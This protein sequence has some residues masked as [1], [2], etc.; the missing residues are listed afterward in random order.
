MTH[1]ISQCRCLKSL[2]AAA[3]LV[4]VSFAI[5][6]TASAQT[7]F[8]EQ[9]ENQG[10]VPIGGWGP[11]GLS[12]NG[13]I[14]KNYSNPLGPVAW[15][16]GCCWG[17]VIN[18]LSGTGY[19]AAYQDSSGGS[20]SQYSAW[21]ILPAISGQQA[22]DVLT[23]YTISSDTSPFESVHFE[24]RY[25]PSG[26]VNAGPGATD[27]GD[28]S[29]V[30]L[31]ISPMPNYNSGIYDG[32]TKWE[33]TLPGPGRIAFRQMGSESMYFGVEDVSVA[34][35]EP[36][37]GPMPE[38]FEDLDGVCGEGPCRLI[39]EQGW[40]FQDKGTISFGPAWQPPFAVNEFTPHSGFSFMK[41]SKGG[42]SGSVSCWAVLPEIGNVQGDTLNF[43]VRGGMQEG[44][45]FQVRYSPTGATT[46]GSGAAAVGSFT[47]V[48]AEFTTLPYD[49]WLQVGVDIPGDGRLALRVFDANASQ[50]DVATIVA[51]DTMALNQIPA[52]PPIPLAN[53]T[54]TWTPA[55]NPVVVNTNILIP[56]GATLILEPGTLV[57]IEEDSSLSV[58]GALIGH[59]TESDPVMFE[60]AAVF[61]PGLTGTGTLDLAYAHINTNI[62]PAQHGS[63]LFDHCT[64]EGPYAYIFNSS[65]LIVNDTDAPAFMSLDH[66]TFADGALVCSDV[67]LRL[68]N[69]SFINGT[70]ALPL[71]G[72]IYVDNLSFDGGSLSISRDQQDVYVNNITVTNSPG[73]AINVGGSNIGNNY[74]F[75]PDNVLTNNLYPVSVSGGILPGST[76][77]TRGNINNAVFVQPVGFE[78]FGPVIWSDPGIPYHV[79]QSPYLVGRFDVLPGVTMK[80]QPGHG[81]AETSAFESRGLPD[82]P[83]TFEGLSGQWY[84]IFTPDRMEYTT[85]DGSQYGII[86]DALGLPGFFDN[87]VF[88]HND[89]A[90]V[91][92]GIVRKSQF[93][94]NNVG[95]DVGFT[96]DLDGQTNPNWF[97]G[98]TVA[99]IDASDA[100]HNWW[101][102]PTGPMSSQNPGGQG[103][104]V[105]S[106]IPILP[107]RTTPPDLS[108]HPP[109]IQ[110]Q[111][112]YFV[113]APGSTIIL[114]WDAID[115]DLV[116]QRVLISVQADVP[117]HYQLLAELPA[118]QRSY[119]LSVPEAG[120]VYTVRIEGIDSLGQVGWDRVVSSSRPVAIDPSI[121]APPT[122]P[123]TSFTIGYPVPLNDAITHFYT[124]YVL[125]DGQMTFESFGAAGVLPTVVDASSDSVRFG[126]TQGDEWL[127]SSYF[128]VRPDDRIGDAAPTVTLTQPAPG[129]SLTGGQ[130]VTIAWEANDDEGVRY[131]T[132]QVSCDGGI[133]FHDIVHRIPAQPASYTWTLPPLDSPINDLRIR[134]MV[135]DDRFQNSSDT[136][137]AISVATGEF[138][139]P[140]LPGDLNG[141]GS[142]N[143]ADLGLLLSA[144]GPCRQCSADLDGDGSVNG[145]DLG[146]LLSDWTG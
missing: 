66:C 46:T 109:I 57:Q 64:F 12:D 99:V 142:V 13:W 73:A 7:V 28:F 51:V 139:D 96:M 80:F 63:Y 119:A 27:L 111:Q 103:D 131:A 23:F 49:A 77:P 17:A 112:P 37:P 110:L 60:S 113:A 106:G 76:L 97:E 128:S 134:V 120:F 36:T 14:F 40:T 124:G 89:R 19:L 58:A 6:T 129:A 85:V 121:V 146:L 59:G 44:G 26:G 4:T 122:P 11:K 74:L 144:W 39:N 71:R 137:A 118:G 62:L 140:T 116:S 41:C 35:P 50:F 136:T 61:P 9:F 87:C 115:D 88:S 127:F 48:L 65:L 20:G 102:D 141:D 82:N 68:T 123:A 2:A 29:D 91:G 32:W 69:T 117:A 83:V 114:N 84:G 101:G 92:G 16:P 33:V 94:E 22:G 34:H 86:N 79:D 30:L 25:S 56:E 135:E 38:G 95:A 3:A 72:Y 53:E 70:S 75:G 105:A 130:P 47:Q 67:A 21:A 132:I 104:P 98:N 125:L 143:G 31:F 43:V 107:F 42:A 81:I 18:P 138:Q 8:S 126:L 145:A 93:L 45:T 133:T 15:V 100:T 10:F 55:M 90:M 78:I 108:N 52:G 54:V 1:S 24:V 5:S